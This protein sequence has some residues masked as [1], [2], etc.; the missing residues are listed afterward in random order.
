MVLPKQLETLVATEQRNSE[1][2][3][4]WVAFGVHP[5]V[6]TDDGVLVDFAIEVPRLERPLEFI[7]LEEHTLVCVGV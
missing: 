6:A 3:T 2:P 5:R 7:E 4:D 1:S